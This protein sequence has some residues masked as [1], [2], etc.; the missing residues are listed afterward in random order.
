MAKGFAFI[1]KAVTSCYVMDSAET[2]RASFLIGWG[3]KL[4]QG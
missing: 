1:A 3:I 4:P 2:F